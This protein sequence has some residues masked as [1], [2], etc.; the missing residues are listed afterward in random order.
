MIIPSETPLADDV[1]FERLSRHQICGG[2][3]KN[4]VYQAAANAALRDK[5]NYHPY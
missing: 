3:I 4:A 2:D 5:G 1:D